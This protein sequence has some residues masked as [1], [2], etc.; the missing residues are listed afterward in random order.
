M[1]MAWGVGAKVCLTHFAANME[2]KQCCDATSSMAYNGLQKW[3]DYE[4]RR[5][6][7]VSPTRVAGLRESQVLR[8]RE[9]QL[10]SQDYESRAAQ[11]LHDIAQMLH[12]IAQMS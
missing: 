2:V 10:E 5:T 9:S 6:T 11:M 1:G 3:Y 7:R 12:D 4:S 8:L